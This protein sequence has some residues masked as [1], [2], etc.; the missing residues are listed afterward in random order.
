MRVEM[1][2]EEERVRVT[3][4]G[5]GGQVRA[6]KGYARGEH[7]LAWGGWRGGE[8]VMRALR[9]AS[10]PRQANVV[11]SGRTGSVTALVPIPKGQRLHAIVRRE[12]HVGRGVRVG[13]AMGAVRGAGV[14]A[15]GS[16]GV[17]RA[18]HASPEA[19]VG[20]K[21]T[22]AFAS[23]TIEAAPVRRYPGHGKGVSKRV[24]FLEEIAASQVVR[25]RNLGVGQRLMRR[26]VAAARSGEC[27]EIHLVVQNAEA[28]RHAR[29]MYAAL[30]MGKAAESVGRVSGL[31]GKQIRLKKG[32]EYWVGEICTAEEFFRGQSEEGGEDMDIREYDGLHTASYDVSKEVYDIF[33]AAHPGEGKD[34]WTD[35][36]RRAVHCV[37]RGE[38]GA[39]A[40]G[41]GSM[42]IDL[43]KVG[44]P[45]VESGECRMGEQGTKMRGSTGRSTVEGGKYRYVYQCGGCRREF[46]QVA[47]HAGIQVTDR[48]A[49]W[50]KGRASRP[51][52]APS[53]DRRDMGE[54]VGPD[55]DVERVG[56]GVVRFHNPGPLSD[57]R[58][59]QPYVARMMRGAHV[60]AVCEAGL[61]GI[62]RAA[63][64]G[65]AACL[66]GVHARV[67]HAAYHRR[68][69]GIALYVAGGGM[70]PWETVE[71]RPV[72][73]ATLQ[74][75]VVD[76]V[77]GGTP[78]RL[79]ITHGEPKS[80]VRSKVR[81][82]TRVL[83]ALESVESGCPVGGREVVWMGDH[84]MVTDAQRDEER[85]TTGGAQQVAE[86]V[87]SFESVQRMLGVTDAYLACHPGLRS[88]T[89][90]VRRIDRGYATPRLLAKGGVPAVSEM[91]HMERDETEFVVNTA[92]HGHRLH[93]C[94]HKALEMRIR[95]TGDVRGKRRWQYCE[96]KYTAEAWKQAKAAM[97]REMGTRA[98]RTPEHEM[99]AWQKAVRGILRRDE[100]AARMKA[101]ECG[102]GSASE[103][104]CGVP[105][106]RQS[107]G[108][109]AGSGG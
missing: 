27:T 5:E 109:E 11:M 78:I 36:P 62:D 52:V 76:M 2:A 7:I 14:A 19:L 87:K 53:D 26:V 46:S 65:E 20:E 82:L 13:R 39:P 90:G 70:V 55:K 91:R 33:L 30:G 106:G 102:N 72:R 92:Q 69:T 42:E 80:D 38:L 61:E 47:P 93:R 48:R 28:Q 1:G 101:T 17:V 22:L 105:R 18:S 67:W 49:E 71:V 3:W 73:D 31:D 81:F 43:P 94:G 60:L 56:D 4:A 6:G 16:L 32:Q 68:N 25:G 88:Y 86:M 37:V 12:E 57:S 89:H 66:P 104:V 35:H 15:G 95:F 63:A 59:R 64:D 50:V 23:W 24:V 41:R 40:R 99:A 51:P 45:R 100:K 74:L 83:A 103:G 8:G 10:G 79:V 96:G 107:G 34:A 85:G 58:K 54:T 84:N 75:M 29:A 9:A 44:C 77:I 98:E 108:G 21:G 97:S